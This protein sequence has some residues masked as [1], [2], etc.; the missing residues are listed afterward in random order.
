MGR[1]IFRG[2]KTGQN[3]LNRIAI[4]SRNQDDADGKLRVYEEFRWLF[5]DITLED[6]F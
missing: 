5:L 6:Y 2:K 4:M 3:I 1:V